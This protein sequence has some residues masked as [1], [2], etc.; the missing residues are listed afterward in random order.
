[1]AAVGGGG[2][3]KVIK[4]ALNYDGGRKRSLE[5]ASLCDGRPG[6]CV[7]VPRRTA[8]LLNT[9]VFRRQTQCTVQC[10]LLPAYTSLRS[11]CDSKSHMRFLT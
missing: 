3:E 10:Y 4:R 6:V 8:A 2:R 7:T 9:C 5:L 11:P 1:M